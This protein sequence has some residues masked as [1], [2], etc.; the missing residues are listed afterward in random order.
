MK[1]NRSIDR[2]LWCTTGWADGGW[3]MADRHGGS[4]YQNTPATPRLQK[5]LFRRRFFLPDSGCW[6]S[7]SSP[8]RRILHLAEMPSGFGCRLF[9][10]G[11]AVNCH[12][13]PQKSTMVPWRQHE[14]RPSG[15]CTGAEKVRCLA[16]ISCSDS[17]NHVWATVWS[18]IVLGVPVFSACMDAHRPGGNQSFC[19]FVCVGDTRRVLYLDEVSYYHIW[20][21]VALLHRLKLPRQTQIHTQLKGRYLACTKQNSLVSTLR[22]SVNSFVIHF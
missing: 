1:W 14:A 15:L 21:L 10:S 7:P 17:I 19:L 18:Q 11:F 20:S 9:T 22:V 3:H 4:C 13:L 16:A 8:L 6:P 12:E 2:L 5:Q